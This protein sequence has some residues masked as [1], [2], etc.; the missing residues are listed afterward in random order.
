MALGVSVADVI[1]TAR[2]SEIVAFRKTLICD[3]YQKFPDS[4]LPK[5][6]KAFNRDHSTILH[7]LQKTGLR[8][9][10]RRWRQF[11]KAT[12]KWITEEAIGQ[13]TVRVTKRKVRYFAGRYSDLGSAR[14]A[15]EILRQAIAEGRFMVSAEIKEIVRS[16]GFDV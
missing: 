8:N 7:H 3:V 4:S 10:V 16:E 14:R 9:G 13:F 12:E 11:P 2:H 1:G 15:L 5:I 6:G